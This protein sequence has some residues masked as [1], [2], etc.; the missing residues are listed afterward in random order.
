MHVVQRLRKFFYTIVEKCKISIEAP[1]TSRIK[2]TD[3]LYKKP[4]TVAT[5]YNSPAKKENMRHREQEERANEV[6]FGV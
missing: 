4:H 3:D 1:E 5:P 6:P 2:T